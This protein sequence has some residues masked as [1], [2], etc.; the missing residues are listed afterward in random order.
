MASKRKQKAHPKRRETAAEQTRR[1]RRNAYQRDYRR[2]QR[3]AAKPAPPIDDPT[4]R[5]VKRNGK[6][7]TK[8]KSQ[9]QFQ[10]DM[11][12]LY[13]E[14]WE[15][16]SGRAVLS[17]L[18]QHCGVATLID[19]TDPTRMAIRVGERN[20]ALRIVQMLGWQPEEFP[21]AAW[22]TADYLNGLQEERALYAE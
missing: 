1:L 8:R 6:G 15:S 16:H 12:N 10:A 11:A 9:S 7:R 20:M 3:E 21:A 4:T 18:L 5:I 14:A 19:D 17:D 13:R 2:R 22:A